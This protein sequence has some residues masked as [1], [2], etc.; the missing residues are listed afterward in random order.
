L[1]TRGERTLR[2]TSSQRRHLEIS[3][4]QVLNEMEE[5]AL[6]FRR[7]PLP[8]ESQDQVLAAMEALAEGIAEMTRDLGLR[9]AA[10]RPDPRR[11]LESLA[12]HWWE[13]TLN[14]RSEVLRGYGELDPGTAPRLDP[15]VDRLA[16]SLFRLAALGRDRGEGAEGKAD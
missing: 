9:P 16:A 12:S 1:T 8:G 6:W 11:K 4:G 5:A 13:T 10:L 15:L 7:W 14:C 3:L 2:L